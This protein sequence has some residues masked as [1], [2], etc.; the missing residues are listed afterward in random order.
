M[1]AH[2]NGA[3]SAFARRERGLGVYT[4]DVAPRS[5]VVPVRASKRAVDERHGRWRG[6]TELVQVRGST[7]RG[8]RDD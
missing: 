7:R 3:L 1:G 4:H 6:A 2:S 5:G 8:G